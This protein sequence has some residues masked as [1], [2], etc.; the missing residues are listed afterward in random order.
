MKFYKDKIY[1]DY[2]NKIKKQKIS[3]IY[4]AKDT[5]V[6]FK[7]GKYYNSKNAAYINNRF[8]A[9]YLNNYYG[10]QYGFTKQSWRRFCKLQVFL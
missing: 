1:W 4:S 10:D 2:L 5:I 9:F 8:K 7:D 3:S 6:F